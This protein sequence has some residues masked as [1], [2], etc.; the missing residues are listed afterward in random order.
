MNHKIQLELTQKQT[1]SQQML[2][3][4]DILQMSAAELEA[5][6]EAVSMENPVLELADPDQPSRTDSEIDRQ[7]KL[8]WLESTDYQNKVYYQS[9]SSAEYSQENLHDISEDGEALSEYLNSQLMFFNYSPEEQQILNYLIYSLDSK[10]YYT[11]DPAIPAAQFHVSEHTVLHLLQEIQNLD[12]AG[13]G[14]R[15]L[16]ECLVLQLHRKKNYSA[17]TE[18]VIL[19]H[20]D[21]VAKNHIPQIA[22]KMKVTTE[23]VLAACEEIRTFNPKPGNSF[24]NRE[25]LR[26]ISPDAIVIKTDQEFD[27]LINEYQYPRFSMNPFYVD[28][29]KQTTDKTARKYLKEKIQQIQ[30]LSDSIGMRTSTL[31][32]VMHALVTRQKLFF[33]RG[34]GNKVPM[35]LADLAEDTGLHESTISRTLHSKYLQCSWGVFPLN[36]FLTPVASVSR[37]SGE[38]QT[39]EH[40]LAKIREII[41][42]E[43]KKKPLSDEAIRKELEQ[44]DISISR[45]TVNKYR[46]ELGIPDKTGR[47]EYHTR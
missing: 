3:Y 11:E 28:L 12:P 35:G 20:L 8:E 15:D 33:L 7:R 46:Q 17:V 6:I 42:R 47:K 4:M 13:V 36:Y 40:I 34:P 21:E 5:H 24:S 16:K 38:E 37:T 14:A 1:I 45:R 30:S 9:D 31:S 23:D 44:F 25:H 18:Q 19:F 29:A 2:Q 22:K 41:D 43:D 26:Y 27:I 10:G 39:Q 32:K